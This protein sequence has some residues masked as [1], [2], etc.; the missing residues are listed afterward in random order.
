MSR[1]S[2]SFQIFARATADAAGLQNAPADDFRKGIYPSSKQQH[3]IRFQQSAR[4]CSS[5][6]DQW[7]GIF[8]GRDVC[9]ICHFSQRRDLI[10]GSIVNNLLPR[11]SLRPPGGGL[12]YAP[13]LLSIALAG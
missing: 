7:I 5:T 6:T 4:V 10:H 9:K 12:C 3:L 11:A 13:G 8:I 2:T 1:H